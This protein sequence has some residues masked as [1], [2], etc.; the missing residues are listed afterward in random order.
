MNIDD[1]IDA[2]IFILEG[3]VILHRSQIIANMLS[4]GRA[5]PRENAFSHLFVPKF[6]TWEKQ[7][8]RLQRG[9]W[10]PALKV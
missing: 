2:V 9:T 6:S 8:T 10:W 3:H 1:A 7:V 5:R 4:A